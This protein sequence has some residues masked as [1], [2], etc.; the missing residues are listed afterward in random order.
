MKNFMTIAFIVCATISL[1]A[2]SWWNTKKIKG[3]G[4]V[5]T[6][7]RQITSFDE[8]SIGGSFDV[9]LIDGKEGTLSI[10]G[11]QNI[12][13]HIITEV[14]GGTLKIKFKD[15]MNIQTTRRLTVTVPFEEIEGVSLGGSGH[16]TVDKEVK[17]NEVSFSIGGSGNIMA[18]VKSELT[19]VSIGGSGNVKL[20]G[21]TTRFKCSIAGSGNVK[22]YGLKT[23]SL[24]ASIAGSGSVQTTVKTKIKASV[25]GS[26]SVYYKGN[27]KF[28]DS[29]AI[30]SGDVID[31]N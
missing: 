9:K 1:Q 3:N 31:K 19:K 28:I 12:L 8:V 6:E 17:S 26:G 29:N 25:V 24:K 27:P 5:V 13:P 10:E 4:N 30:G 2:Q 7:N 11:E 14:K 23:D 16:V 20:R 21:T 18:L 22:A 15:N